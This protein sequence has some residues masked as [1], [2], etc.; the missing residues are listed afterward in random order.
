M[1]TSSL[2]TQILLDKLDPSLELF[3]SSMHFLVVL[4]ICKFFIL[5]E[6]WLSRN[7]LLCSKSGSQSCSLDTVKSIC[8]SNCSN[9]IDSNNITNQDSIDI[10]HRLHQMGGYTLVLRWADLNVYGFSVSLVWYSTFT[11]YILLS[12]WGQT[13]SKA[14]L[15]HVVWWQE[16]HYHFQAISWW[17]YL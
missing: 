1:D 10:L 12:V 17:P 4:S 15:Q 11:S 16:S 14:N 8:L 9:F 7:A 6:L 13:K 2:S 3:S 5:W